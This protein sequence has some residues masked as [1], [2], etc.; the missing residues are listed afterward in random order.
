[1]VTIVVLLDVVFL[2]VA[3]GVRT[4]VQRR[5][6]GDSGWR[7]GR[8]HGAA[9]AMARGLLVGAGVLLGVAAALDRPPASPPVFVMG[10]LVAAGSIVFVTAAQ[11]QMGASWRIGV[12]PAERTAL[13]TTGLFASVRNPIYTGMVAFA[14]AQAMMFL[15]YWSAAAVVAMVAGV[16]VQVRA[17]EEPYLR[18]V[19]GRDFDRWARRAG[20][21]V[22]LLGRSGTRVS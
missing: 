5:R 7:L 20:R 11:L 15:G 17:V 9:E 18:D 21:F 19:H 13:I 4:L 1:M 3:F 16:E 10:A 12:D 8:P 2:A 14:V 6:T 22:P